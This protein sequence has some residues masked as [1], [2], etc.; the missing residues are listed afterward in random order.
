[1]AC[2]NG[3]QT[4]SFISKNQKNA[5]PVMATY[6]SC[7]SRVIAGAL[8]GEPANRNDYNLLCTKIN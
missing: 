6:R 8:Y 3:Y 5:W 1:M 4:Y 2:F 7:L